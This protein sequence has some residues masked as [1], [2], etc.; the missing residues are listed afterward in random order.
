MK[1]AQHSSV[2]GQEKWI[3]SKEVVLGDKN[4]L[5]IFPVSNIIILAIFQNGLCT[6]ATRRNQ[7]C[8]TISIKRLCLRG[9][10]L[11]CFKLTC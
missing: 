9:T 8:I 3:V 11:K 10:H 1:I 7:I 2:R 6:P 5:H 4:D